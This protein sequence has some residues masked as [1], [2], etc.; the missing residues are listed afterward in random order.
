MD[1]FTPFLQI[2]HISDLHVTDPKSKEA[3]AVRGEIRN[4][5]GR[6]PPSIVTAIEDGTAPHDP[7]AIGLFSEFLKELISMD[8]T[9]SACKTWLV[10]TG[11]LTSLGDPQSLALGSRFLA[12]LGKLCP[13][14]ASIYGNHDAWPG[15]FPGRAAKADVASQQKLLSKLKYNVDSPKLALE[16]NVP[17]GGVVHLYVLDSISHNRW[18]NLRA[19][20]EVSDQQLTELATLVDQNYRPDQ[21]QFRVLALHHPIHYP[22]PRPSLQMSLRN[23]RR[24]ASVLDTPSPT[25]AYP[26]AHLV[27]SGHTHV[28][29]PQHGTLPSQPSLCLHP[30]LGDEQCQLVVGSLM[31]LDKYERRGSWPHQCEILRLYYSPTNDSVLLIERLVAARQAGPDYRGTGIGPY[32][33][34]MSSQT[35]A[36]EMT[37]TL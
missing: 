17:N 16:A 34:V 14:L 30:H 6:L 27:L 29:Y 15:K 20:G 35:V 1:D 18:R 32:R 24:V 2:V 9:W 7:T 28:L 31:Q 19:I 4:M 10:D 5:R 23:D 22:P 12:E 37:F 26:L 25:G 36:E 3:V 21:R 11:D 8:P 33:F 13:D